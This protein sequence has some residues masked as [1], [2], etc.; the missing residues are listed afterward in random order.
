MSVECDN[1]SSK[2]GTCLINENILQLYFIVNLRSMRQSAGGAS[3]RCGPY[4]R[5]MRA[6]RCERVMR[7][8]L[9]EHAIVD[10]GDADG[11]GLRTV[12]EDCES[13]FIVFP[14]Q[15]VKY[16][17]FSIFFLLLSFLLFMQEAVMQPSENRRHPKVPL[18]AVPGKQCVLDRLYRENYKR[19][20]HKRHRCA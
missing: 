17:L 7:A 10:A 13:A 8:E 3:E 9:A 5:A 15:A 19:Y 16:T 12:R 6:W 18:R 11:P 2:R 20:R 14:V 4:L 1:S